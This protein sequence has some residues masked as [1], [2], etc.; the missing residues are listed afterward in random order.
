MTGLHSGGQ[1][2]K[3]K[4]TVSRR[5]GESIHVDAK[6]RR[7]SS[8]SYYRFIFHYRNVTLCDE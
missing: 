8:S 6:G 5:G 7:S 1:R 4:V 3:V 2:S